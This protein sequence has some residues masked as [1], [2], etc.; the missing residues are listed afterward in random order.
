MWSDAKSLMSQM[1][2][3][4]GIRRG[5]RAAAKVYDQGFVVLMI[6]NQQ[7]C[8]FIQFLAITLLC[9]Q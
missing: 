5:G 4:R 8:Y 9:K 1:N 6:E 2:L 3:H 7:T